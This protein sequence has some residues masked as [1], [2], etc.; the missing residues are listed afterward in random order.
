MADR[1]TARERVAHLIARYEPLSLA[2]LEATIHGEE[3]A[4]DALVYELCGLTDEEI[5]LVKR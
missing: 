3:S 1:Q 5:A 2:V 4:L